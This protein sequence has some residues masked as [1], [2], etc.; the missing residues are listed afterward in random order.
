MAQGDLLM[1]THDCGPP[2]QTKNISEAGKLY[3]RAFQAL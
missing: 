1:L 2:K 3:T